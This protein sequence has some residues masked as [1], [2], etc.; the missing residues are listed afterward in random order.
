MPLPSAEFATENLIPWLHHIQLYRIP[1]LQMLAESLTFQGRILEIGSGSSWLSG[2]LSKIKA[3]TEI[4]ALDND[5]HRHELARTFFLPQL[6][7]IIHKIHLI[8]A[9]FNELPNSLGTFD[10]IVCDAALHHTNE[11]PELLHGLNN[12][13]LP[14]GF[15]IA[16]REPILP[17][18]PLLKHYRRMTFG[19]AQRRHGDIERIYSLAAWRQMFDNAGFEL[20]IIP[21]F[22]NTTLKEQLLSRLSI[23]NLI[24]FN[25]SVLIGKKQ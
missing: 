10:F 12:H 21:A 11:L 23:L 2:E 19:W 6:N 17:S 5:K 24:A 4:I 16:M 1:I 9:D 15:I 8:Q 7:S 18:L 20:K 3:V 25:R 14:K 22:L 13:L